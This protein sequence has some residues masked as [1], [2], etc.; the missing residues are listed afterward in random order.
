MAR[1]DFSYS[2]IPLD[3]IFAIGENR[4]V[5]LVFEKAAVKALAR[6]PA[7]R[8]AAVVA[9]LERIA[10][11]PFA[12]HANVKR[13]AGTKDGFRLRH[14]DW[15]ALYYLAR[16]ADQMVVVNIKTRGDAYK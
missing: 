13:L 12:R 8:A 2:E 9:A 4:L 15:R 11:E 16:A 7:K 14:G 5:R 6:M 3:A 1:K 10:H